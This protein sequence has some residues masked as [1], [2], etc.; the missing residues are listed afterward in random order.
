[1]LIDEGRVERIDDRWRAT[2]SVAEVR[3]PESIHALLAARLDGLPEEARRAVQIAS[4]IGEQFAAA[5]L[6]SLAP[7]LDVDAAIGSLRRAGLV[8]EDRMTRDA[9]RY[10]FKHLLMRDVAYAGLPKVARADLHEAFGAALERS[11]GDRRDEFAE[12]LAH[13]AERAFALS[14]EIRLRPDAVEGRARRALKWARTLGERAR[15]RE[16]AGLMGPNA[17][18]AAAAMDALGARATADE[19]AEVALMLA[20]DSRLAADYPAARDRFDQAIERAAAAGRTDLGAWSHLGL[21]RVLALSSGGTGGIAEVDKHVAEAERSFIASGDPGSALEAGLTALDRFWAL[22]ELTEM[23]VRGQ[24]LRD[25]ARELGDGPRELL[26]C[27]RLIGAAAQAARYDLAD[28][29]QRSADALAA[30]LGLRLPQWARVARGG[31]LRANGEFSKADVCFRELTAEARAEG[32]ALLEL[33]SLR[34]RAEL[35]IDWGRIADAEPLLA[36][37]LVM[38]R[39][40][41]ELWNRTELIASLGVAAAVSGDHARAAE[42]LREA[43]ASER[44]DDRYAIAFV[45]WAAGRI[46]AAAGRAAEA[47]AEYRRGLELLGQ[48]EYRYRTAVVRMDYVGFLIAA[49]RPADARRELDLALPVLGHVVGEGRERLEALRRMVEAAHVNG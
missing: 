4:V 9:G 46:H 39:Q 21:A 28:E 25:R 33:A 40:A 41:G 49:G 17:A 24:A 7:G 12:V 22:G 26:I 18:V 10:R 45:A 1:M 44:A 6:R 20:D 13:H 5:E 35:Y 11:R 31:R 23:L 32:D 27:A 47:D 14:V 42:L 19:R 16:D 43:A 48:T 15:R 8:L 2:A 34:N 37:A 38:S 3:V 36:D 29:F 30:Q